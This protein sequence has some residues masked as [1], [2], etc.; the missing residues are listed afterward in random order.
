MNNNILYNAFIKYKTFYNDAF[1]KFKD[2]NM[3]NKENILGF[4][5][6]KNHLWYNGWAIYKNKNNENLFKKSKELLIYA[7]DIDTN[8]SINQELRVIIKAMLISPKVIIQEMLQLDLL[9]AI[10]CYL[11]NVK[12]IVKKKIQDDNKIYLEDNN[13]IK[14]KNDDNIEIYY[15]FF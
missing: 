9:I 4:Y 10:S 5:D 3:S 2:E 6:K 8:L 15:I 1:L 12:Y 14:L 11:L 7:L 13:E